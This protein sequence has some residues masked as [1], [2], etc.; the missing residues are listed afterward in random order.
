MTYE[1]SVPSNY[2]DSHSGYF[3]KTD[4][5]TFVFNHKGWSLTIN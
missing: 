3:I 2:S 4:K 5:P 1:Y